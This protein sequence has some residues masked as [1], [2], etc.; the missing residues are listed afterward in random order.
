MV[1]GNFKMQPYKDIKIG[2]MYQ[3]YHGG[4]EFVVLEK[5]NDDRFIKVVGVSIKGDSIGQPFWKSYKDS[6][7]NRRVLEG[8]SYENP[9]TV[10]Q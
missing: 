4:L 8:S 7:F 5:D 6:L 1:L 3:R 10:C 9:S 2:D